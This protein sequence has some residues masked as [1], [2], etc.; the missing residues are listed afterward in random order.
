M[1]HRHLNIGY[2]NRDFADLGFVKE[3]SGL[4]EFLVLSIATF[5]FLGFRVYTL[6][7][8]NSR[9]HTVFCRNERTAVC[10]DFRV[11]FVHCICLLVVYLEFLLANELF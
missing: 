9:L 8:I 3:A 1:Q 11:G 5:V 6:I 7:G 10:H 4:K 2:F